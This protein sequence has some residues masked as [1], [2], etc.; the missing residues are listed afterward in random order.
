MENKVE[1][2]RKLNKNHAIYKK[3]QGLFIQWSQFLKITRKEEI[4]H[5]LYNNTTSDYKVKTSED[6]VKTSEDD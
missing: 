5:K 3:R 4:T 1:I 6:K 2:S